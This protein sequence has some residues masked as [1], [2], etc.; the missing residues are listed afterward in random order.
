MN[1]LNSILVEGQLISNPVSTGSEIE[2][3][4]TIHICS[5][6]YYKVLGKSICQESRF[7]VETIGKLAENCLANLKE[8]K[9]VRV[10]GRLKTALI[11]ASSPRAEEN[12]TY[13]KVIIQAEHVEFKPTYYPKK[14]EDS[15]G[16][17]NDN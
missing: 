17:K 14:Q 13:E 6:T 8:G 2:K 1:S 4:C 5:K 16:T 9:G 3:S 12:V 15:P 10:V 11:T 7:P